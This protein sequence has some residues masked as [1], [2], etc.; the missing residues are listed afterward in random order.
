VGA[1][2]LRCRT[3]GGV[4]FP[5]FVDFGVDLGAAFPVLEVVPVFA[6]A[7][8]EIV[9]VFVVGAFLTAG[10]GFFFA[11]AGVVACGRAREPAS[12]VTQ[13]KT[14]A[15]LILKKAKKKGGKHLPPLHCTVSNVWFY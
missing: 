13:K 14:R 10:A 9:P 1:T 15:I 2:W 12:N 3:T 5:D 11:V 7:D 6:V 8:L 4:F